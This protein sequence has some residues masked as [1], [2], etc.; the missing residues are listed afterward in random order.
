MF[1]EWNQMGHACDEYWVMCYL[2]LRFSACEAQ[3]RDWDYE[4]Y[5]WVAG[6]LGSLHSCWRWVMSFTY[7]FWDRTAFDI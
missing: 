2:Y 7:G 6:S 5:E 3:C 1:D 4:L